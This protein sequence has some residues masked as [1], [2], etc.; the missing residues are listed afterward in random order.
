MRV[1][2]KITIPVEKGNEVTRAGK[3]GETINALLAELDTEA[4]YL[5]LDQGQRAVY[6]F[7]N[8]QEAWE[9]PVINEPWF[10]A[11][12]ASIDIQPVVAPEELVKAGSRIE[13]AIKK[14]S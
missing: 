5:T 9:L 4:V 11:L 14:Y 7:M 1:M 2:I 8:V 12:N 10:L 6:I 3:M 13:E